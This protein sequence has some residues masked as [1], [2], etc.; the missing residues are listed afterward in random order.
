VSRFDSQLPEQA[1]VRRVAAVRVRALQGL[2]GHE[3]PSCV[4][5]PVVVRTIA[6]A[7]SRYRAHLYAAHCRL[8]TGYGSP[9]WKSRHGRRR[10]AVLEGRR[11]HVCGDGRWGERVGRIHDGGIYPI[12]LYA[13][14]GP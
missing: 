10:I 14:V 8:R 3:L 12:G 9:G 4:A 7:L 2:D 6:R 5:F 1:L 13:G 11:V